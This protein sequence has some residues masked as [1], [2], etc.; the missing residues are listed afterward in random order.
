M[1]VTCTCGWTLISQDAANNTSRL[2]AWVN[3]T[4]TGATYNM[5]GAP[6][7]YSFGGNAS[8]EGSGS[9]TVTFNKN[10]YQTQVWNKEITVKHSSDGSC[11]VSFSASIASGTSSGTISDYASYSPPTLARASTF[12][13]SSGT[14]YFG[15]PFKVTINRSSSSFTHKIN[16]AVNGHAEIYNTGVGTS[17]NFTVPMD[18]LRWITNG[19]TTSLIITCSTYDGNTFIG[20]NS[21]TLS[22]EVPSSVVPTLSSV[23]YSDSS[24]Y[25][26]EYGTLVA[27]KSRLKA[28]ATATGAYGSSIV[29]SYMT[30]GGIRKN[31]LDCDFGI[32]SFVGEPILNVYAKDSRGRSV[33]KSITFSSTTTSP[34]DVSESYAYRSN[35]NGVE[36]PKGTYINVVIKGYV[37]NGGA[38]SVVIKGKTTTSTSWST[39]K[40]LNLS[41]TTINTSYLWSGRST[42]MSYDVELT[43]TDRFGFLAIKSFKISTETPIM[44]FR[45]DGNGMGIGKVSEGNGLEIG[46]DTSIIGELHVS[47][48]SSFS[49]LTNFNSG[50]TVF[51]TSTFEDDLEL[52]RSGRLNVGGQEATFSNTGTYFYCP[53]NFNDN[54]NFSSANVIGL[55]KTATAVAYLPS[56]TTNSFSASSTITKLYL[57]Y[58]YRSSSDAPTS[59]SGGLRI[60][61]GCSYAIVSG[62]Y[63]ADGCSKEQNNVITIG[64]NGL[65]TSYNTLNT[66]NHVYG[67][68]ESLSAMHIPATM[69]P[70]SSG[71]TI[72]LGARC[73]PGYMAIKNIGNGFWT[74]NAKLTVT[75][76]YDA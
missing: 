12:T 56:N 50:I 17:L 31:G 69:I 52:V 26:G 67:S 24:G 46:W 2:R 74:S 43:V 41:G 6:L 7:S 58:V 47:D 44:D 63:Y 25:L 16:Y 9:A 33:S 35:S 4:T 27:G 57:S 28:Y 45:N 40:T 37:P 13:V 23:S 5:L 70:V 38:S 10:W 36:S 62:Y 3:V 42:E 14:K 55:G 11:S 30:I 21:Q 49:N 75:C 61:S 22:I 34:P 1:A 29:E 18:D 54:V 76:I 53:V 72:Y 68:G 73:N 48:K 59:Y 39:I 60:P 20:S 32:V 15:V 65:S 66:I 64:V 71:Q 19:T 8:S 51:G